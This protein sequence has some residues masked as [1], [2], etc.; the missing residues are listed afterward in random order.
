ML[1]LRG[2]TKRFEGVVALRDV[3]LT[4]RDGQ[5][6]SLIGPNG[7]GK[8]TLFN[9]VTGLFRP[10]GG[11]VVF[12]GRSL[13]GLK[14]SR[15]VGLGIART[16]QSIRL[17][18]GLS[19]LENVMAGRHCRTRAG[20]VAALLRR[21]GQRR[22]EREIEAQALEV[23]RFVGLEAFADRVARSLPYGLQ[24]RLEIARALATT[25]RL[26][27]LDEPA[28][29]TTL[30]EARDLMGLIERIRD[31]GVTVLLIEHNMRVVM[32]ISDRIAVLDYGEKIAE[33]SP[34][35]IQTHPR[36][37][38]AYLGRDEEL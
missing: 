8:T 31:A 17:F 22:E 33:G 11:Q 14:P 30:P 3:G 10:T 4:V 16:F 35:E 7:A 38:E 24:R 2:V 19:V 23:L 21:P 34:K 15:I 32:E 29:G 27:I 9:V 36:V 5:I 12:Q 18:G 1:D 6:V 26:V 37:I 28:C 13:V 20:V 25:P